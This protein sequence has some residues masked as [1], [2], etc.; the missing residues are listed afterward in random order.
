MVS[1]QNFS[2]PPGGFRD[3]ALE[4]RRQNPETDRRLVE[5]GKQRWFW[6]SSKAGT[7][8]ANLLHDGRDMRVDLTRT[9]HM[10]QK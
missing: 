8:Q 3:A 2:Q 10:S 6:Q 7:S 4:D 9:A 1:L 5:L